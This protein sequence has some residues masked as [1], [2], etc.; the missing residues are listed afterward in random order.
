MRLIYNICF[1]PNSFLSPMNDQQ[2]GRIEELVEEIQLLKRQIHNLQN[3]YVAAKAQ[4]H[5]KTMECEQYADAAKH[6]KHRVEQLEQKR[7]L[8]EKKHALE[9]RHLQNKIRKQD[10]FRKETNGTSKVKKEQHM[11]NE[12]AEL[13]HSN[14]ILQHFVQALSKD[15]KFDAELVSKLCEIADDYEDKPLQAF[16]KGICAMNSKPLNDIVMTGA[17]AFEAAEE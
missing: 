15:L 13:R 14:K 2:V 4:I 7:R 11:L 6:L 3:Q 1:S 17:S 10:L 5:A 8:T 12:M 16:I 9:T